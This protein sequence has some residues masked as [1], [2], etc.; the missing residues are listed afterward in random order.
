VGKPKSRLRT[1]RDEVRIASNPDNYLKQYPVWKFIDFDWQGPW[2]Y[3]SCELQIQNLRKHIESHLA[4]FETMTWAE[5]LRASGGRSHGTNSH[6]IPTDKLKPEAIAR[7]RAK[8]INA[9]TILS[10]RLDAG[11]RVYGVR[12]GNCLRIALF[13]P[14]HK[15]K[16][17]CAYDFNK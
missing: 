11:T 8:S 4:S 15:D 9:D 14:H 3:D 1:R 13:D 2:G 16:E 12:E 17:L 5:I 7:L 10:L 6:E